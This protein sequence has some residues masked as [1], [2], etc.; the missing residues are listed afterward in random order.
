LEDLKKR[1]VSDVSSCW[2][3]QYYQTYIWTWPHLRLTPQASATWQHHAH[4]SL[5]IHKTL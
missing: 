1:W 2:K 5:Q 4:P 3:F